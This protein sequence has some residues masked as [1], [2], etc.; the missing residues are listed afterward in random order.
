MVPDMVN[1]F[2]FLDANIISGL[3][4]LVVGQYP[5]GR[6]ESF[7]LESLSFRGTPNSK[8][9]QGLQGGAPLA[10]R[11]VRCLPGPVARRINECEDRLPVFELKAFLEFEVSRFKFSD[12]GAL[13]PIFRLRKRAVRC[14]TYN[15]TMSS[16]IE[17]SRWSAD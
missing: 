7:N 10:I 2:R 12:Q 16:G 15:D 8:P 14:H 11:I 1:Q 5:K 6:E 4:S 17:Q 9:E 3:G 13:F